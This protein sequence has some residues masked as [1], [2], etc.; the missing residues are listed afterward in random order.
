M[1]RDARA[2]FFYR[3][4]DEFNQVKGAGGVREAALLLFLN[5]TCFNGLYRVNS[6]GRFNAPVGVY[7]HPLICDAPTLRTCAQLLA[8]VQVVCADYH[9]VVR[10]ATPATWVYMDPPYRPLKETSFTAYTEGRFT[11]DDQRELGRVV[12]QLTATGVPVTLSNSD[13]ANVDAQDHFFAEVFGEADGYTTTVVRSRHSVGRNGASRAP[14]TE[15]LITNFE[16]RGA[17]GGE[18]RA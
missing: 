15:L 9:D 6:E 10:R 4:R 17:A 3:H 11:V 2:A 16:R 7:R 8:N 14:L 5:K 1:S 18:G 13:P 12:A